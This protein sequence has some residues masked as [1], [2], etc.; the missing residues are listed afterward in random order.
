[1]DI[2]FLKLA[3]RIKEYRLQNSLTQE[4]LAEKTGVNETYI[5]QIETGTAKPS[6]KLLYRLS[7]VLGVSI[8]ILLKDSKPIIKSAAD[9]TIEELL[10]ECDD[11]DKELIKGLIITVLKN[12]MKE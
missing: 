6:L 1:M 3:E 2:N 7:I 4:K 11:T 5:S 10:M 12:K 8:D 9:K